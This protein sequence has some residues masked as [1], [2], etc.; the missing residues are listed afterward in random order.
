MANIEFSQRLISGQY[1]FWTTEINSPEVV[2]RPVKKYTQIVACE[3]ADT[4]NRH[5]RFSHTKYFGPYLASRT[6]HRILFRHLDVMK[7]SKV[8]D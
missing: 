2:H 4:S 5:S 1:N 8:L 6:S 7:V 3:M